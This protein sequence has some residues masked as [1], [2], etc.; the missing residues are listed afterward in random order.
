CSPMSVVDEHALQLA[1]SLADTP[2]RAHG[3]RFAVDVSDSDGPARRHEL[4]FVDRA[5]IRTT[6]DPGVQL[7][8]PTDQFP[9]V[10]V[11]VLAAD[12]DEWRFVRQGRVRPKPRRVYARR[13]G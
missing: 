10:R 4:G 8:K 1:P 7:L 9:C 2:P 3:H 12:N 5:A 13:A 11:G 6:I